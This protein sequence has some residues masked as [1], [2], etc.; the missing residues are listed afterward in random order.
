VAGQ[1]T[2]AGRLRRGR[3]GGRQGRA[4][5]PVTTGRTA[6]RSLSCPGWLVPSGPGRPRSL[7]GMP[8]AAA[9]MAPPRPSKSSGSGTA[10]A[11]SPT[12]A[13]G[14]CCSAASAGTRTGPRD[15][16]VPVWPGVPGGCWPT[17]RCCQVGTPPPGAVGP[18][19]G[20]TLGR[21]RRRLE[22][23]TQ[24]K[25]RSVRGLVRLGAWPPTG[26]RCAV[27]WQT[28]QTAGLRGRSPPWWRPRSCRQGVPGCRC[29][30]LGGRPPRDLRP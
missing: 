22:S 12:T 5:P 17:R 6:S 11:T 14:C 30:C 24:A 21:C 25:R 26:L 2:A 10:F 27:R 13:C 15:Y 23:A 28:R 20:G 18:N 19:F 7:P 29:G 4:G 9:P 3:H 8:P 1:R 16:L